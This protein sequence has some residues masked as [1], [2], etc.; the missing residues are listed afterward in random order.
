MLRHRQPGGPVRCVPLAPGAGPG[1]LHAGPGVVC[2]VP[3]LL[4]LA[5]GR[6]AARELRRHVA[7]AA[8]AGTWVG[9][10]QPGTPAAPKRASVSPLAGGTALAEEGLRV[11]KEE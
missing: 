9:A 1:C 7:R 2:L 10:D 3:G 5:V 4:T 8:G 6:A 11:G